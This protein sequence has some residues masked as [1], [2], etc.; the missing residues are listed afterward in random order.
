MAYSANEYLDSVRVRADLPYCESAEFEFWLEDGKFEG[1]MDLT[2]DLLE[3]HFRSILR[4][5]DDE[6]EHVNVSVEV[7]RSMQRGEV[8]VFSTK[9]TGDNFEKLLRRLLECANV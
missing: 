8:T 7:D 1:A 5:S 9:A 2:Q 4:L 3:E 6:K